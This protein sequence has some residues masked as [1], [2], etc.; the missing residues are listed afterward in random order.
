MYYY[1]SENIWIV[2]DKLKIDI[3]NIEHYDIYKN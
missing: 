3:S 2:A 1:Q